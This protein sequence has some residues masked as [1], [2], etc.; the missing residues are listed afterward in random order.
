[1]SPGF[2]PAFEQLREFAVHVA[3]RAWTAL[4][5]FFVAQSILIL[6]WAT[7]MTAGKFGGKEWILISISIIGIL[8][9]FQ[10]SLLGTRMWHYH[11][12]Y[13]RQMKALW[14]KFSEEMQGPGARGWVQVDEAIADY[15]R[16]DRLPVS[17][18]ALSG[19]QSTLLLA[20]LFL[21]LVH[22]TML[23]VITWPVAGEQAAPYVTIALTV[24]FLI[25]IATVW[26]T[27][28]PVLQKPTF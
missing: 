12:E 19:N 9:G 10:F 4:G 18:R 7:L 3:E 5:H 8:M 11:L 14:D 28:Q 2:P 22:F 23:L 24:A 6:A 20:P 25:F 26:K 15:W 1:M 16:K 13:V 27:C 17:V 21:A